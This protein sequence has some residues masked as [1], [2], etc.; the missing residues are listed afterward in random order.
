[1]PGDPSEHTHAIGDDSGV[2]C[3]PDFVRYAFPEVFVTGRCPS[4]YQTRRYVN[5]T[6]LYNL[7]PEMEIRY[8]A[9]RDDLLADT[10]REERLYSAAVIALRNHYRDRMSQA[11]YTD[12]DGITS[13]DTRLPARGYT[14]GD[15]LLVTVWNDSD[16][17]LV[18][19]LCVDGMELVSFERCGEDA[20]DTLLP[21]EPQQVAMAVYRRNA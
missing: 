21:L 1:M 11:R 8:K 6:F 17:T 7:I 13:G 3:F 9:D 14:L 2:V 16:E 10:Y 19:Q 18:P 20:G 5:H 15:E 4:N 12:T